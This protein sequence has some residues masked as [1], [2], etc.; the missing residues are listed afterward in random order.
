MLAG[1]VGGLIGFGVGAIGVGAF[2]GGLAGAIISGAVGGGLAGGAM[3]A[4][5]QAATYGHIRNPQL[6]GAAM[7]GGVVS[8]GFLGGIGYG[9][10]QGLAGGTGRAMR[11]G[12]VYRGGSDTPTNLTPRPG[13]D[14]T[15]LSTF[16]NL[17][18]AVKPGGKAQ[19]IDVS[20][21]KPP[22][23][24]ISDPSP[25]GHVSIAPSNPVLLEEWAA[26]RGTETIHPLTQIVK[27]AIIGVVWRPR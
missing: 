16:D 19:V 14:T 20:R 4:V 25:P 18:T 2:G 21:L 17:E 6:V 11:S 15:G 22:L 5:R 26:T 10:R 9:I 3:E 27:D 24:A 12:V 7:L 23:Q 8:G 1:A 13:I